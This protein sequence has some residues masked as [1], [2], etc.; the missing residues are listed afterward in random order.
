MTVVA[1][2]AVLITCL[3]SISHVLGD[4]NMSALRVL[5]RK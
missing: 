1:V 5:V 4:D 3:V 2:L